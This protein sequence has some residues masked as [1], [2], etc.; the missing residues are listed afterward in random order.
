MK[1]KIFYLLIILLVIAQFKRI[2]KT[3]PVSVPEEDFFSLVK[4]PDDI[5]NLIRTSCYD[6][7]SH[8]SEYP[9][10]SDLAPVSWWLADHITE[11]REHMNFSIWGQFDAEKQDHKLEECVEMLED[12]EMPMLPYMIAHRDAWLSQEDREQLV[13]FFSSLR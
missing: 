3:N 10:Y 8:N 2:D 4:A 13:T 5:E 11:G 12:K 1:K 7:H 9:W 6:C